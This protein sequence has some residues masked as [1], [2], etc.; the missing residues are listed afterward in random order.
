MKQA[1]RKILIITIYLGL[2]IISTNVYAKNGKTTNETTRLRKEASTDSSIVALISQNE[3]VEIL[4]EEGD[5]YKVKYSKYTGYVRKDM[6]SVEDNSA[7]ENTVSNTTEG[8]LQE[9]E[10]LNETSNAQE[11]QPQN[12]TPSE[13]TSNTDKS[14]EIQNTETGSNA[15]AENSSIL[16]VGYAGKL[17]SSLEIK[18]L[19]SINSSVIATINE[20]TEFTLTD[21]INKWCYI[22]TENNSGWVLLSK[23]KT[24]FGSD[25][26][27]SNQEEKKEEQSSEKKE[28]ESNKNSE[29]EKKEDTSS[30]TN[31]ENKTTTKY[32]STETL[33]VRESA[34]NDAKIV[35]QLTINTQVTVIEVV[36]STWSKVTAKGKT[37]YVASKFLS[38]TKTDTSSRSEKIVRENSN[39]EKNNETTSNNKENSEQTTDKSS[40]NQSTSS[41]SG[42]TGSNIVAYAKKYLGSKYVSGGTSPSTGFDCSGFTYYVY[43]NFG[44]TLNR[45]STAQASNGVAVSRANL[46][47]GDLVIF[48]NSSNSA[49]GHVGIYIGGNTFIHAANSSKGVIT[50]SMSDS[51]YAG[52]F[53]TARR[54]I[55]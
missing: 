24:D 26:I 22:Q 34:K 45:T 30:T 50:T 55:Y 33:N 28:D 5:W 31:K 19:P 46:Q 47:A 44:I 23:V 41:K 10:Q 4:E 7:N 3:E 35:S 6:L 54:I 1:I 36:D 14:E 15:G 8:N 40:S 37:G 53:V 25:A 20:N 32:V 39:T 38:D 51:Y 49:I 11:K 48:N 42:T 18:I 2:I 21:I 43:K 17:T 16:Q 27:T 9:T 13:A 52:R 12:E 29:P